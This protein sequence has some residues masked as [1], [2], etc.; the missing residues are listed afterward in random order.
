ME[1]RL[2]L[3]RHGKTVWN[4]EGRIQGW[5][6]SPLLEES[7]EDILRIA[8]K[9]SLL[10]IDSIYSSPLGR[11]VE[12]ADLVC[13]VLSKDYEIDEL[14]IER[15]FGDFE[16]EL[17]EKARAVRDAYGEMDDERRW[18]F[19][20]HGGESYA[21]VLERAK[22]FL[23]KRPLQGT[24]LIISHEVFNKVLLGYLLQWTNAQTMDMQLDNST[25][26]V[27]DRNTKTY[28]TL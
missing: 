18:Q 22:R 6:N 16:G 17:L 19:A 21:E 4:S 14:I 12:T 1:D 23:D 5:G 8:R 28:R 25:V 26:F 7:K 9:L 11:C 13:S 20:W 24:S 2:L 10:E 3:M 27:L 15:R